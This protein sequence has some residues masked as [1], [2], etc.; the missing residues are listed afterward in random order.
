MTCER[1][2]SDGNKETGSVARKDR[3][4]VGKRPAETAVTLAVRNGRVGANKAAVARVDVG[5]HRLSLIYWG[6]W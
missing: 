5:V 1:L 3:G 2:E 4:G 6:V